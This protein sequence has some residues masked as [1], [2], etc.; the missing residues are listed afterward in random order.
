[1]LEEQRKIKGEIEDIL[2]T[3]IHNEKTNICRYNGTML[4]HVLIQSP[5]RGLVNKRSYL[6]LKKQERRE[7]S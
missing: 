6:F 1:M 5:S 3:R 7:E 2:R 4:F